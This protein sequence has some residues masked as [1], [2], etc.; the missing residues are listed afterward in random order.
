MSLAF[1][2]LFISVYRPNGCCLY[3][4]VTDS[5]PPVPYNCRDTTN[6]GSKLSILMIWPRWRSE[7]VQHHFKSVIGE[8]FAK[9]Y[10]SAP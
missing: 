1:V 6:R 2:V 9:A 7:D 10:A 5:A 3:I 4:G 8:L